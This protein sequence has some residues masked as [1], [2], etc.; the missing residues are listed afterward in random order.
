MK[1]AV[2]VMAILGIV[3]GGVF[4]FDLMSYPPPVEGRDF[5]IDVAVGYAGAYGYSGSGT[6]LKIPPLSA[7]VE[8][9]LPVSVPISVGGLFAFYQYEWDYGYST[10]SYTWTYMFFGGR[11]NWHWNFDIS[12]LDLY[13]GAFIGYRYF[14]ESYDGPTGWWYA[15]A[16]YGGFTMGGQVGAHFYFTKNIGALVETGYPFLIKAGLALKF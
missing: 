10:Y 1:K 6:S 7:S 5:L 9:A 16:N 3:S 11:A 13:T 8:Y 4:A 2:L 12:W 15:E 14:K